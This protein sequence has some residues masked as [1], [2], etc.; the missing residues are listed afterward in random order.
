MAHA[1]PEEL[2][3]LEPVFE[4]LRTFPGLQEKQYA[5]F[6]YK[7]KGFLHFHSKGPRRWADLRVGQ[8]W[9]PYE[10]SLPLQPED[11]Q[12]FLKQLETAFQALTAAPKPAK[13][14]RKTP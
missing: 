1:R 4:V 9:A 13:T 12:R 6:Y 2:Q 11:Y 5:I 8:D 3:D 7:G 10:L 14:Q